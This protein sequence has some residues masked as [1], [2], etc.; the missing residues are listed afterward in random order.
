VLWDNRERVLTAGDVAEVPEAAPVASVVQPAAPAAEVAPVPP[1]ARPSWRDLAKDAD[2]LQ[3]HA[4][5]KRA[6]T[7]DIKQDPDDLLLAADV[8][9]LSGH[10]EQAVPLL[11]T[12]FT[13]HA[14]DPRAPLAAFTLGRVLLDSLGQPR[15]A[16]VAFRQAQALA[17]MGVLNEDALAREIEALSRAADTSLAQERAQTYLKK[18]PSGS[19]VR[20]VRMYGGL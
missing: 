4:A 17:P 3:A 9:R 2:F 7:G 1:P 10:P 6:G 14:R 18:Y 20:A 16:A 15:E 11:R 5:L 12:V 8:L 13:R 19:K